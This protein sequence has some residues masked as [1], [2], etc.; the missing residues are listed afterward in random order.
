MG[1]QSR[2]TSSIKVLTRTIITDSCPDV[3]RLIM[4][5][6]YHHKQTC[7]KEVRVKIKRNN[8]I[9]EKN[10]LRWIAALGEAITVVSCCS[11]LRPQIMHSSGTFAQTNPLLKREWRLERLC[12]D[13]L[14]LWSV[15]GWKITNKISSENV[16][17]HNR[18]KTCSHMN[19]WPK[20]QASSV[21]VLHL[22]IF[23][24]SVFS[25]LLSLMA[26]FVGWRVSQQGGGIY[27]C[28][29]KGGLTK[30]GIAVTRW[31]TASFSRLWSSLSS[32]MLMSRK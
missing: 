16:P 30:Q 28:H 29:L 32:Q 22:I 9:G 13:T 14:H 27:L 23:S 31:L 20:S 10:T 17:T 19:P 26:S 2:C 18:K 21:R 15:I 8:D 7:R 4:T 25:Q 6:L 11:D 5:K 3:R 12:V 1:R 24:P